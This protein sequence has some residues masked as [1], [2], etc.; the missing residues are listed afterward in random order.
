MAEPERTRGRPAIAR[1]LSPQ[2]GAGRRAHQ[3]LGDQG[4]LGCHDGGI[5]TPSGAG[6]GL[7]ALRLDLATRAQ[8]RAP[9]RGVRRLFAL[10]AA[11][12]KMRGPGVQAPI[13][14][15][16][17]HRRDEDERRDGDDPCGHSTKPC[18]GHDPRIVGQARL[19]RNLPRWSRARLPAIG[20][21]RDPCRPGVTSWS[22]TQAR[23]PC[24]CSVLVP[25]PVLVLRARAPC[26][27]SCSVLVL[28]LRARAPCS[29]SC[30]S[31]ER[32]MRTCTIPEHGWA[33]R[34]C[35]PAVAG[36]PEAGGRELGSEGLHRSGGPAP[37]HGERGT[38]PRPRGGSP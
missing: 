26:S 28:V 32:L 16:L 1:A 30:T 11:A 29:C 25:V 19:K 7:A 31:H 18:H 17:A 5:H 6:G 21:H 35:P 33:R 8:F 13:C 38:L 2:R 9:L 22:P 10:S 23:A 3:E 15:P 27:C 24:P 12:T 37:L 20:F 4:R 34:R 36:P 14:V